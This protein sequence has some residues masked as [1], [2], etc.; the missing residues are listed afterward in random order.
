MTNMSGTDMVK[1]GL[2]MIS[3]SGISMETLQGYNE[4]IYGQDFLVVDP[5]YNERL[6]E[7]LQ[8][9]SEVDNSEVKNKYSIMVLNG[10]R[11]NGLAGNLKIELENLGYSNI[12]VGNFDKTKESTI[13]SNDK[14]LK[15]MLSDDTGIKHLLKNK[16]D[17]YQDYDAVIIIGE[18]YLI[19][20]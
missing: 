18:D 8:I 12:S 7:S 19:F 9:T 10:T 5:T 16:E 11:V 20:E 1:Y 14:E 2:E 15:K 6:L 3:N 13:L 4:R 17:E